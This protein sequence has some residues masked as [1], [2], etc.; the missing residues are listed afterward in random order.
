MLF[1]SLVFALF[2]PVVLAVYWGIGRDRPRLQNAFIILASYVFY[3]W[4]DARFLGLIVLS[5][6]V[7]AG[8][9]RVRGLHLGLYDYLSSLGIVSSMQTFDHPFVKRHQVRHVGADHG[10]IRHHP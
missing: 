6:L 9:G 8:Q 1:N 10:I 5:S 4:W 2:L 7:R 3:G